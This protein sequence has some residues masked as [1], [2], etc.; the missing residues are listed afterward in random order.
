MSKIENLFLK[1]PFKLLE[2]HVQKVKLCINHIAPLYKAWLESDFEQIN[3]IKKTIEDAEYMADKAKW[4]I[5]KNLPTS[6]FMPFS[7]PDLLRFIYVQDNIA[8]YTEKLAQYL[9]LRETPFIPVLK[10][11]FEQYIK[12]G[13]EVIHLSISTASK[14]HTLLETSFSTIE[15]EKVLDSIEKVS[16]KEWEVSKIK[17]KLLKNLYQLEKETDTIT[18]LFTHQTI[19][20]FMDIV[21]SSEVASIELRFMLITN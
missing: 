20:H 10:A 6:I 19:D 9:S 17:N 3:D 21:K 15:V 12:E 13:L 4:D 18:L 1:S 14:L 5:K 2:D 8:N 11:D 16:K 7:R